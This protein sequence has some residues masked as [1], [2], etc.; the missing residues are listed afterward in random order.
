[1]MFHHCVFLFYSFFSLISA[2]LC[3]L[4]LPRPIIK[5]T[6]W[7][8]VGMALGLGRSQ[9]FGNSP[10]IFT[11][12]LKLATFESTKIK[13][14]PTFSYECHCMIGLCE[15]K[16][17]TKFEVAS[18]RHCVN[19]EGKPQIFGSSP[20]PGSC[21]P[22]V[23]LWW[24]LANPSSAPNLKSLA[25]ADAEILK[26]NPTNFGSSPSPRPPPFF[27]LGVISWWVL[28]KPKRKPLIQSKLLYIFT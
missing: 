20:N 22:C 15:P 21:P 17:C 18:F 16:L 25:W 11:Q 24:A 1:M 2:P 26:G 10:S 28:A 27:S 7:K 12:W 19:I 4:R 14:T 13:A 8:R 5:I 23:I 9:T 6:R 3:S